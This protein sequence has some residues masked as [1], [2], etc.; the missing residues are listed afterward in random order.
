[1]IGISESDDGSK[2]RTKME[3]QKIRDDLPVVVSLELTKVW[4][5]IRDLAIDLCPK[6]TGALAS[7]IELQSE[8]GGGSI[9]ST[10]MTGEDFY[11]NSI[12]AGNDDIVNPVT[13]KPTALYAGFVHDGHMIGNMMWEGVPFLT[14]AV[15]FYED[16]LQAAVDRAVKELG[17]T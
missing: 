10:S 6:E 7:S 11:S 3:L 15:L 8:G 16:E 9:S 1:M 5:M 12:F 14:E 17:G 2:E 13:G 4:E